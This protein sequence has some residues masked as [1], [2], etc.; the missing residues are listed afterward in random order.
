M[1]WHQASSML[2]GSIL[3]SMLETFSQ[4]NFVIKISELSVLEIGP[5]WVS[6]ISLSDLLD[7]HVP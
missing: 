6:G 5:C 4:Y 3:S 1:P 2:W 7:G